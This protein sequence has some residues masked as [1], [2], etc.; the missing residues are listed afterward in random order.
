LR[1]YGGRVT[2]A[3]TNALRRESARAHAGCLVYDPRRDEPA[4]RSFG[5][6][7][8]AVGAK[9]T[10]EAALKAVAPG[11]VMLHI[12]LQDWASEIDMR[13]LTLDEIT[14]I[15]TYTYTMADLR[16]TVRALDRSVFGDLAWVEERRLEHGAAAFR[17]LDAGASAAAKIILTP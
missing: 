15:G 12:G 13:K 1:S 6:V 10:R 9:A 17:D 2:L 7:I 3:E 11:G 8:D 5:F 16:A 14:L 4:A